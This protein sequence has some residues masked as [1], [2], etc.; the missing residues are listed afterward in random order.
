MRV[1]VLGSPFTID[2]LYIDTLNITYT[3]Y[4][5]LNNTKKTK[6]EG[7]KKVRGGGTKERSSET[8]HCTR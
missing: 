1:N 4:L 2:T 7:N 5:G 8:P 3:L 6:K